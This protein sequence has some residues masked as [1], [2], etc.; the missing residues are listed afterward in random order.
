MNFR[1]E[2]IKEYYLLDTDVENIFI[3]EYMAS[4]PGDFVKVYLFALMYAGVRESL[5]ND[6]I[7]RQLSMKV[8]DVEK[9]WTYWESMGVIRKE[10]KNAAAEG[11]AEYDLEFVSLKRMLYGKQ[12]SEQKK[13]KQ[14]QEDRNTKDLLSNKKI[15]SMYKSI[16]RITGR[17]LNGTE[18]MEIVSWIQDYGATPEIVVY[19][20]SYCK[21]KEKDNV[22]YISAVVRQWVE[23]GLLDVLAVEDYLKQMDEKHARYR[24]VYKALGFMR[25]ATEEEMRIM[26]RWFDHMGFSMDKVL[27]ACGKTSGI[28][29]PSINYVN[30]ILTSWYEEKSGNPVGGG[31]KGVS[32]ATVQQYY[33]YLRKMEEEEA[34]ARKKEV[35]QKIPRVR[36]LEDAMNSYRMNISKV[37]L[38]GRADKEKDVKNLQSRIEKLNRERAALLTDH[39]FEVDYMDI[40]YKCKICKDTGTNDEGGR[41]E[42]YV[43]RAKEA[44]LWKKNSAKQ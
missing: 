37:Y 12:K 34:E 1:R 25:N 24:R 32:A 20:Y 3:N 5:D 17:A 43:L 15:Q 7:A 40:H 39:D 38:S 31:Q 22:R 13:E 6:M 21:A 16:E 10:R 28:P 8:E 29:N 36:E 11:K 2:E 18:M 44:E 30:K 9:A 19:A 4:A 27:E 42:C 41:C 35:Y 26:D 33:S 23:R 14:K